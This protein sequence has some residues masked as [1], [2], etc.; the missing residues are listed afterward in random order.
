MVRVMGRIDTYQ[1]ISIQVQNLTHT[2]EATRLLVDFPHVDQYIF[3]Q[4][5]GP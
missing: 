2:T 4:D 3:Q 1:Y 5:N